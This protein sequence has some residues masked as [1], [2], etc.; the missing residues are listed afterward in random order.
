[1]PRQRHTPPP[2]P[3]KASV[4]PPLSAL[5]RTHSRKE[6]PSVP[7]RLRTEPNF[8][9]G[10]LAE[11]TPPHAW[12][13]SLPAANDRNMPGRRLP[14]RPSSLPLRE[15]PDPERL[16]VPFQPCQLRS[17]EHTSELQSP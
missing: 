2:G 12:T 8:P 3:C 11:P 13:S 16:P 4:R 10:P 6:L 17:E 7:L 1:M 5:P 14:C 9:A 15:F